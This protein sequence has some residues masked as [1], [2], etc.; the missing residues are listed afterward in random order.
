MH[1]VYVCV[2]LFVSESG[3]VTPLSLFYGGKEYAIDKVTGRMKTTPVEV[4]G[5]LTERFD[6]KIRGLTKHLYL[7]AAGRW[8]VETDRE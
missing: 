3:R 4:G 7:D 1:K 8:F 2:T 5:L 6:C